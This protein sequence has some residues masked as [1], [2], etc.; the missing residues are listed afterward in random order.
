[1]LIVL[2]I[3]LQMI[4]FPYSLDFTGVRF[5]TQKLTSLPKWLT[6]RS[7]F[8]S[9]YFPLI[10]ALILGFGG[11]GWLIKCVGFVFGSTNCIFCWEFMLG[12]SYLWFWFDGWLRRNLWVLMWISY[13]VILG[14]RLWVILFNWFQ[15]WK[16][17]LEI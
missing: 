3:L 2:K 11:Y 1:M 6:V 7:N 16:T 10:G 4:F 8:F 15:F 9:V 14:F 17:Y 5:L 13:E 12:Y